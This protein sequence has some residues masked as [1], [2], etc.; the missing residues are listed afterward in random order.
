[1]NTLRTVIYI[2]RQMCSIRHNTWQAARDKRLKQKFLPRLFSQIFLPS[3]VQAHG[4]AY[5]GH[6]NV[7]SFRDRLSDHQATL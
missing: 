1:M 3:P 2:L 6:I 7:L 4:K 5:V